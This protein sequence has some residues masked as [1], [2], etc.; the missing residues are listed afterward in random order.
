MP[1]LQIKKSST[2]TIG[3]DPELFLV[4]N[5]GKFISSI[6]KFGG[7]KQAPRPLKSHIKGLMVQ[8]DNVAVEFNIPYAKKLSTFRS[9]IN[10]GLRAIEKEAKKLRLKLSISP[11]A[12]FEDDQLQDQRA[13]VFGCEP[14]FNVWTLQMNPRPHAV[15]K[16]LRS[17][18]GHLHYGYTKDRIGLGRSCDLFLGCPSILFDSDQNRR[19]LYGKAGCIRQKSYGIEYR[20][21]SN[22]W[23]KSN[24][25]ID[26][27]FSQSVQAIKFVDSGNTIPKQDALKIIK[28]INNSDQ[29]LL[30]ELTEKYGLMY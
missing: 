26:M 18:G 5:V 28:C 13:R 11:S 15:N 16:N 21:L 24:E 25:L 17:A 6:G 4:N 30:S 23:L 20:T 10:G 12:E 19:L 9:Y 2:C 29:R 27:V 7:T 22:F 1:N 8:E 3:A 14:D